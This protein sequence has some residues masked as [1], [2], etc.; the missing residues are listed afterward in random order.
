MIP[1]K[2]LD[3]AWT[4]LLFGIG[5]CLTPE[6]RRV[7]EQ[8]LEHLWPEGT[9]ALTC[10]SVRSGFDALLQTLALEPGTEILVSAITIRDMTRIIEAHGLVP[11]PIDLNMAKLEVQPESMAKAV[12]PQTKAILVAHL[13]GSRM[14]M[15]PILRF[16]HTH[17]LLVIEDC[18]QAYAGNDYWG[19]PQSDV[20][21]FSFGPIKTATALAAGI[22]HFRDAALGNAVRHCQEQWP[23]QRRLH[24]LTR[25]CKYAV[26]LLLSYPASYSL[27]IG[28]CSLLKQ[29]HD[30]MISRSVRGFPGDDL[31]RQIRQRPSSALLGLLERRLRRFN[32]ERI[33][34][35]VALA[36]Q[37]IRLTPTLK[38]PGRNAS[39]HT[40]WVVPILCERPEDLM[41]YLWRKGFDATQGGSS[42]SVVAPPMDRPELAPTEANQ[43][44]QQLLYLPIYVGLS[45]QQ[46]EQLA[47]ALNQY[48][49]TD[50]SWQ[51]TSR[52]T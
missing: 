37:L 41:H 9:V 30:Q 3:I 13:F 10:L 29:N 26:L 27:L 20:R 17:N 28:V 18:A 50:L 2:R 23:V 42:L 7:V 21:L 39:A 12:T 14:P 45:A 48:D 35:R 36:E 43:A 1:R 51:T 40:H 33:A 4:D 38:H 47:S 19:H 24:F 46:I 49:R 15:E 52:L 22:L 25:L 32:P 11:V 5:S 44:F 31:F 8:R 16:A 6:N 34:Q